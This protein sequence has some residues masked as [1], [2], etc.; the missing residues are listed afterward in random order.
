MKGHAV[1]AGGTGD[2]QQVRPLAEGDD[3]MVDSG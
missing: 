2:R 1:D 3:S